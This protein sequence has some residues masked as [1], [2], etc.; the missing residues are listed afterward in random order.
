[1]RKSRF[2]EGQIVVVLKQAEAGVPVQVRFAAC[3]QPKT[4]IRRKAISYSAK[5]RTAM[6][7]GSGWSK[8]DDACCQPSPIIRS[9]VASP[10]ARS[11]IR[12][13]ASPPRALS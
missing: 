7:M 6:K 10:A 1:M 3:S 5:Q 9:T 2:T 4:P 13:T 11:K 12:V 8:T